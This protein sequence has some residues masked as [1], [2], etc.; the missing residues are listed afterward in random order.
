M[1]STQAAKSVLTFSDLA[2]VAA[3]FAENAARIIGW[4]AWKTKFQASA[5]VVVLNVWLGIGEIAGNTIS[6]YPDGT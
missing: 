3:Q 6:A 4:F 2:F 5:D 1:N